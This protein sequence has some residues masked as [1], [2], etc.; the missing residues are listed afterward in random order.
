MMSQSNN[1][2]FF[3]LSQSHFFPHPIHRTGRNSIWRRELQ[4]KERSRKGGQVLPGDTYLVPRDWNRG[5]HRTK[6]TK[7]RLLLG[8]GSSQLR[9]EKMKLPLGKSRSWRVT[10]NTKCSSRSPWRSVK[11]YECKDQSWSLADI[12]DMHRKYVHRSQNGQALTR[13]RERNQMRWELQWVERQS[14]RDESL[15]VGSES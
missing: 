15:G 8:G 2:Y 7:G 10:N 14:L 12:E 13:G 11:V 3:T 4:P 5:W 9:D 6:E 1:L